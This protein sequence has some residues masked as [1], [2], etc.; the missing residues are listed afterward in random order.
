MRFAHRLAAGPTLANAA[1]KRIMRAQ[2]DEGTRGA[3]ART[4]EIGGSPVRDRGPAWRRGQVPL[5]GPGKATFRGTLTASVR[6]AAPGEG[7]GARRT[8]EVRGEM[9]TGTVKWFNDEKG[10]GFITPDEGDRD[11]FVH[12]SGIEGDGFKTLRRELQGRVRGRGRRQ[13]PEGGERP[14]ALAAPMAKEEKIEME[15]E[16][17]EALPNTMFKVKLD[18]D[19]EVLGPHLRQ[20][21]PPL[22]P[23]PAGRPREDRALALRPRSRPDHL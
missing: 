21:A 7:A 16:I 15:G 22:H 6:R 8:R 20:D 12:F 5:R 3:D 1:T 2:T 4:A 19:H 23:H 18:N 10:F 17:L 13:G 11:L 14:Q 9:P